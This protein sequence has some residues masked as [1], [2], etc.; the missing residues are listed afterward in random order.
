MEK[1]QKIKEIFIK[2]LELKK[3]LA[4]SNFKEIAKKFEGVV[5]ILEISREENW[6]NIFNMYKSNGSFLNSIGLIIDPK[7]KIIFNE[8]QVKEIEKIVGIDMIDKDSDSFKK[9]ENISKS[10]TEISPILNKDIT[11]ISED[12]EEVSKSDLV[13]EE[14]TSK[15][16]K[17]LEEV[18][19][20]ISK[21]ESV[22]EKDDELS[23]NESEQSVEY[24]G[25]TVETIEILS[26]D[27]EDDEEE[28]GEESLLIPIENIFAPVEN[29]HSEPL[30]PLKVK[31][32]KMGKESTTMTLKSKENVENFRSIPIKKGN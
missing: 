25:E 31:K 20:D 27:D 13:M 21:S 11:K 14:D 4:I 26:T 10:D 15:I 16:Y 2:D 3:L 19:K 24:I 28:K 30:E 1:P 9:I 7:Y 22:M 18:V 32:G 6:K 12:M 8:N 5:K 17:D 23:E 29:L